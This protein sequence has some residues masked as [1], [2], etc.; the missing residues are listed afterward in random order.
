MFEDKTIKNQT[1]INMMGTVI[2]K[3]ALLA[4]PNV[5]FIPWSLKFRENFDFAVPNLVE[6]SNN[7]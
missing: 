6:Q 1:F 4:V 5:C 3:F 7:I 2:G